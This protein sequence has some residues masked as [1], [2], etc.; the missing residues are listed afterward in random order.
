MADTIKIG[1]L[2]ID[3]LKVGTLSVDALYIGDVKIYPHTVAPKLTAYYSDGSVYQ[4]SC[5]TSTT[6]TQS[7]VRAHT[8]SYTAMTSAVVG[9][10]VTSIGQNAFRMGNYTV[11]GSL[12]SITLSNSVKT[13]S[14]QAFSYNKA[15]K[16]FEMP[17]SVTSLGNR[18]FYNCTSLSSVTLSQN[19]TE[20]SIGLF[21]NCGNLKSVVIPSGV[22]SIGQTAFY[23]CNNLTSLEIPNSVTTIQDRAFAGMG[24]SIDSG[25]SITIGSGVTSIGYRA[26]IDF[27]T[28]LTAATNVVTIYATTPPSMIL[29]TGDTSNNKWGFR[30]NTII[31][32]PCDSVN[33]YK[34][35]EYWGKYASQIEAIPNSCTPTLKWVSY[36][37][38]D[39]IPSN[40]VYKTYGFKIPTQTFYNIVENG[41]YFEIYFNSEEKDQQLHPVSNIGLTFYSEGLF[42]T[43]NGQSQEISY[44]PESDEYLEIIFSDYGVNYN[45]N[46]GYIMYGEESEP[47]TI[48]NFPFDMDLYEEDTP[49]PQTLQWV[50]FNSGDVISSDLDIYG[51]SGVSENL[52]NTFGYGTHF[53]FT[54]SRNKFDWFIVNNSGQTCHFGETVLNTEVIS[55][56]CSEVSC[57]DYYNQGA[58]V[59]GTIQ[60]YIY[61]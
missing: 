23:S 3:N 18:V 21:N 50:T 10:C 4:P 11:G 52:Y 24:Q 8:T 28:S 7:E 26:F 54:P 27:G 25:A 61:A 56:I 43:I 51:F 20:I 44:D 17:N 57:D 22:T 40:D 16:T 60:L 49:T 42:F 53:Q 34:A 14:T 13:I 55:A 32:V 38:G 36:S 45:Y 41:N 9:D 37:E 31:Y 59:S 46:V 2:E 12:S 48:Y 6:L 58:T 1:N 35:D 33:A 30:E 29:S 15:L 19:I 47:S 39:T 5:N